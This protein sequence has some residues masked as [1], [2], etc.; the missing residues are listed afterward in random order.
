[1]DFGWWGG[2]DITAAVSYLTRQPDVQHGKIAVL[3]LSMGGEQAIA[4]L[5]SDPRIRPWWPRV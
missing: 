5:G 1:M 2:R 3:G 4:A